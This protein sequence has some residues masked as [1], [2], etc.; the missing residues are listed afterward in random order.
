[1]KRKPTREIFQG[2]M[3]NV[4]TTLS[5]LIR[6]PKGTTCLYQ[7]PSTFAF[8][9]E[10]LSIAKRAGGIICLEPLFAINLNT[11]EIIDICRVTV[12]Q[13]GDEQLQFKPSSVHICA[14][15][16]VLVRCK[17]GTSVLY[18]DMGKI[19]KI[20]DASISADAVVKATLLYA[21]DLQRGV[22]K[23]IH[24][25]EVIKQGR[26]YQRNTIKAAHYQKFL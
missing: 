15:Y 16:S 21:I 23:P 7:T 20:Y 5:D 25:I 19:N 11:K 14:P 13:S 9:S 22:N 18:E 26:P 3:V 1:M 4:H 6:H 2:R 8:H 17:P 10:A 24:H 12:E